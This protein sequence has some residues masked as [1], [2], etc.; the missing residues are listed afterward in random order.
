[1]ISRI[2]HGDTSNLK[3]YYFLS[4][5]QERVEPESAPELLSRDFASRPGRTVRFDE[6]D[7]DCELVASLTAAGWRPKV[8]H[9][10]INPLFPPAAGFRPR[11]PT[12][13]SAGSDATPLGSAFSWKASAHGTPT[14][15]PKQQLVGCLYICSNDFTDFSRRDFKPQR[16]LLLGGSKIQL[17]VKM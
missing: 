3:H 2:F 10:E 9:V 4:S 17:F 6:P 14:Q 13:T 16:L 1:M 11:T 5:C 12:V 15:A 8:W 7:L